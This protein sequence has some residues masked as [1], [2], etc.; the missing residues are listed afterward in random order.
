MNCLNEETLVKRLF[1]N[2]EKRVRPKLGNRRIVDVRLGIE[3]YQVIEVNEKAEYLKVSA[4]I[5]LMWSDVRLSWNVSEFDNVTRINVNRHDMWTPDIVLFNSVRNDRLHLNKM[6]T[7]IRVDHNGTAWWASPMVLSTR[8][9]IHVAQFPFDR[10]D[11]YLRF[12]SWTHSLERM[13]VTGEDIDT[14]YYAPNQ[15]WK[16]GGVNTTS[17]IVQYPD[18]NYSDVN[19]HLV[20]ERR[21]MFYSLNL[22]FPIVVIT[23]LSMVSFILPSSSGERL[24]VSVTLMLAVTVFMLLIA[25]MIPESSTHIAVVEVYFVFC[26]MLIIL[27]IVALCFISRLYNRSRIDPPMGEWT[28]KYVFERLA[29]VVGARC[30]LKKKVKK[31]NGG[32]DLDVRRSSLQGNGDVFT[33]EKLLKPHEE[34]FDLEEDLYTLEE[35]WMIVGRTADHCLFVVF[36]VVFVVGT[37]GCFAGAKYIH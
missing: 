1:D 16:L 36:L 11:C 20:L 22:I 28:G 7:D 8:C 27:V 2:Y 18:G 13:N 21:S 29:F 35:E 10:Q 4:W 26:M 23:L 5:H 12:S 9:R 3:L 30:E 37:V 33:D 6:E 19:F 25:E 15:E 31:C 34:E 24:G 17:K 14:T 32:E